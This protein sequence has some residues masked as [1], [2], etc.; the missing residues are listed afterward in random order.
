M[1]VKKLLDDAILPTRKHTNDVGVDVYAYGDYI[2]TPHTFKIIRTGIAF[3]TPEGFMNL[4]KPKSRNNWLIGGGV[5]DPGYEGEILVKVFNILDEKIVIRHGDAI[6]QIIAVKIG[7]LSC[8]ES[9][10]IS[11]TE[12]GATGGIVYQLNNREE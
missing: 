9:D 1:P 2:I 3:Q 7:Y 5:V 11:D 12:R 10:F 4:I 8:E 6:A